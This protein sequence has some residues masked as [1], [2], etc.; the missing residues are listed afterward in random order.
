VQL[1]AAI[2]SSALGAA[3]LALSATMGAL[4]D[5]LKPDGAFELQRSAM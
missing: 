4:A 1:G 5:P 2:K 3:A